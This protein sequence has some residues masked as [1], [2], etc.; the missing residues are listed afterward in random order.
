M[1]PTSETFLVVL[2]G[3][4]CPGVHVNNCLPGS[5]KTIGEAVYHKASEEVY[6]NEEDPSRKLYVGRYNLAGN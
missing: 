6:Y 1:E 3:G 4:P 5:I 2:L